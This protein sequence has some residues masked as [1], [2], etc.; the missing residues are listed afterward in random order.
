M[1]ITVKR[2]DENNSKY[3]NIPNE[4]FALY[5]RMIPTYDGEKWRYTTLKF[6]ENQISEMI[7]PDEN[8]DFEL[9]KKD[10][11]FV[12]AYDEDNKCV[13]LAIYR[14]EW[15]KYLYLYD[16]KVNKDFRGLGIGKKLLEEGAKIAIENGYRGIY[17]IAQDNNLT[18]CLFYIKNEFEIGGFNT[19]EYRG[20]SQEDKSN[21]YFYLD[22]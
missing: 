19:H 12:G 17:T 6:D 22:I 9:M 13:G 18:A 11:F 14:R 3:I 10:C 16:L 2:I 15:F 5:G 4:S 21:I 8:Y 20:T 7:F 1:E